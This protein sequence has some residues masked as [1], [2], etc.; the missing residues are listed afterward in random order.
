MLAI[1]AFVQPHKKAWHNKMDVL[2]LLLLATI[3]GCSILLHHKP[4]KALGVIQVLVAYIP[5]LY[6]CGYALVHVV[7]ITKNKVKMRSSKC[8][9]RC[10]D[11]IQ[12]DEALLTST[13]DP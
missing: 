9:N 2:I 13:R 6:M 12:I 7:I 10:P 11:E 5:F 1:N 3:N 8:G 4:S